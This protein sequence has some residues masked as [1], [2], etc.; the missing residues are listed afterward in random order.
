MN[1]LSIIKRDGRAYIESREV[2]LF[3]GKDHR[4]LLRDIRGYCDVLEKS[5]E[6]KDELINFFVESSYTDSRG[7]NKLCYLLTK[8]GC[9]LC[10]NKLA[11]AKGILFTAAYVAKFNALEMEER[12]REAA[13]RNAPRLN[14]FNYAVR[15]VLNGMSQCFTAPNT[16]MKFLRGVYE[17]LGV[18]VMPFYEDDW[19]GYYTVTEIAAQIGLYSDSGRPHGH[20]VS[21]IISKMDNH[22]QH[23]M[24]I[25]YGLVGIIRRYDSAAVEWVRNWIAENHYPAIV[26]YYGF[27]YHIYYTCIEPADDFDNDTEIDLNEDE[28]FSEEEMDEICDGCDDCTKCPIRFVCFDDEDE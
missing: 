17:P 1:A 3:I 7:R 6:L 13:N 2:A 21:A 25:P 22:A 15:N 5:N 23:A 26:P 27:G 10:A 4:N 9:E 11:G 8:Q 18:E 20:A 12:Q 24:V 14:E 28:G 16:V 19:Y